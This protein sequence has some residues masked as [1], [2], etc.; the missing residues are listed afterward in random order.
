MKKPIKKEIG[1]I[2][3]RVLVICLI[4]LYICFLITHFFLWGIYESFNSLLIRPLF[5]FAS[6]EGMFSLLFLNSIFIIYLIYNVM[7]YRRCRRNDQAPY[8]SMERVIFVS[9]S[10]GAA[11]IT[12]AI[13]TQLHLVLGDPTRLGHSPEPGTGFTL[14]FLT[15][16]ALN[17]VGVFNLLIV[18]E[19]EASG[20][21]EVSIKYKRYQLVQLIIILLMIFLSVL[22]STLC[23][24][25]DGIIEGTSVI[26]I[27][28]GYW[29]WMGFVVIFVVGIGILLLVVTRSVRTKTDLKSPI[30]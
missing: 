15:A 8:T 16:I 19:F 10:C 1:L 18:R 24:V 6:I 14:W 17:S 21:R 28:Y 5:G 27:L 29:I 20:P 7:L 9:L 26:I 23:V 2:Y 30:P 4:L 11:I 13:F 3:M 25:Y 22:L 12:W